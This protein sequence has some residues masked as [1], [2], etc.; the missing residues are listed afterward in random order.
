MFELFVFLA[1]NFVTYFATIFTFVETW[2]FSWPG[3]L[4]G[5]CTYKLAKL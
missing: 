5:W 3:A 2:G 1:F 4:L